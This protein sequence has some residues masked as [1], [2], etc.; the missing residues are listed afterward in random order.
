MGLHVSSRGRKR[1]PDSGIG[2][3]G[4]HR[5]PAA[6]HGPLDGVAPALRRSTLHFA[7]RQRSQAC[8]PP[9]TRLARPEL[10]ATLLSRAQS[11]DLNPI[12]HIWADLKRRVG[13]S[14]APATVDELWE[15]SA[16][17]GVV[18][19]RRRSVPATRRVKAG[20]NPRSH[21]GSWLLHSFL[22]IMQKPTN[23]AT[24]VQATERR[25]NRILFN[26]KTL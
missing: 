5:D 22:V 3:F 6:A 1:M 15:R 12:E 4:I 14:P 18:C 9:N 26:M 16:R 20:F 13:A 25:I 24:F 23:A 19:D 10:V 11:P 21:S 7:T 17:T 8:Q 2:L